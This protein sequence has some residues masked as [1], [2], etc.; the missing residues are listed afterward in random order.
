MARHYFELAAMDGEVAARYNLGV[1]EENACNYDRALKHYMIAVRSGLTDSTA[2]KN[3]Q[4]T[5][6]FE[7]TDAKLRQDRTSGTHFFLATK[8]VYS[9]SNCPK[10][11]K[12]TGKLRIFISFLLSLDNCEFS[13]QFRPWWRRTILTRKLTI[14]LNLN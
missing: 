7:E 10:R 6:Q 13:R 9:R 12:L 14:L 3:P 1:T 5:R 2:T 8:R 11:H 4:S